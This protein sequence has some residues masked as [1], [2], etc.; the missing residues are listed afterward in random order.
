MFHSLC[1][2]YGGVLG[3]KAQLFFKCFGETLPLNRTKHNTAELWAESG[4]H[5]LSPSHELLVIA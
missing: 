1:G 4:A 2:V 3:R 5:T